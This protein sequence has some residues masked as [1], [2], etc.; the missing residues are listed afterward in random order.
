MTSAITRSQVVSFIITVVICLFLILA[1]WPPVTDMLVN[2]APTELVD[3]VS[4]FSVMPHFANMQRGVIDLRDLV[5]F[6]SVIV[7]SLFTTGI[8]LKNHAAG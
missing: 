4:A 6:A 5:Y 2:W 7:F 3:A 8:V 1:G